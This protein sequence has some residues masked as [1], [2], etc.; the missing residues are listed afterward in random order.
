MSKKIALGLVFSVMFLFAANV[1]AEIVSYSAYFVDGNSGSNANDQLDYLAKIIATQN[2]D[3]GVTFIISSEA[4]NPEIQKGG[5]YLWGFDGVFDS[6]NYKTE[7]QF[8]NP[9]GNMQPSLVIPAEGQ[10]GWYGLPFEF[11][12]SFADD[13]GWS[14]FVDILLANDPF[15]AGIHFKTQGGG[16]GGWYL[17]GD[18][19]SSGDNSVPEPATLA[20][21][22]LGLAGLG[23]AARRRMKK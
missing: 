22:G 3:N 5:V 1:R 11:T 7:S 6:G 8:D 18:W 17:T 2:D 10:G 16:G 19:A 15:T 12:L 4:N 20:V 13:K 21:I 23:V 9:Y 14:D